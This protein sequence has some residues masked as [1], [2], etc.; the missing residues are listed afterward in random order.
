VRVE[1]SSG[2]DVEIRPADD[3]GQVAEVDF[4]DLSALTSGSANGKHPYAP[5]QLI[6][7]VG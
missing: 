1:D 5:R 6:D 2:D 4:Y 7:S 3:K